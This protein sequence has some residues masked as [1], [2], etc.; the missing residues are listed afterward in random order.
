MLHGTWYMGL[1]I[2]LIAKSIEL[3][4]HKVGWV[5]YYMDKTIEILLVQRGNSG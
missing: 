4:I 3:R 1:M 2:D 5:I